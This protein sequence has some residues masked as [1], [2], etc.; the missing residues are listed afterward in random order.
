MVLLQN[1]TGRIRISELTNKQF[2]TVKNNDKKIKKKKKKS[3]RLK[4][5][6]SKNKFPIDF[7]PT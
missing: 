5:V 2:A 3:K 7:F 4:K 6:Q 1:R